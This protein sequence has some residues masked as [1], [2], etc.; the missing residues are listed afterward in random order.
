LGLCFGG[1]SGI[2]MALSGFGVWSLVVQQL[3]YEC[4]S[5]LVLWIASTWRPRLQFS[6]RHFLH[7]FHFGISLLAFNIVNFFKEEAN[8]FLVGY[9]MGPI[10]LGF[11]TIAEQV[12]A[13]VM[14]LVVTTSSPVA[15]PMFS[16]LQADLEQFRRVF[17]QA[18]QYTSVIALPT[19]LGMFLL[20][21]ELVLLVFGEQW[22]V[23]IPVLQLLALAGIVDAMSFFRGHI[24]VAMGKPSW[25]LWQSLLSLV[26]HAIGFAIAVRLGIVAVAIAYL[27][28]RCLVFPIGQWSIHILIRFSWQRYGHQFIAPMVSSLLMVVVTLATKHL[29]YNWISSPLVVV[30][31]C[32]AAGIVV[33]GLGIRILAPH[34]YHELQ[35]LTMT[36]TKSSAST[37]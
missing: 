16:R 24:L 6:L 4:G 36:A 34:I 26:L 8:D 21:P 25:R 7:M 20:A 32:T 29:L 9:F 18:T 10:T 27:V 19:F 12:V 2:I 28:R 23:A 5:A 17:Y 30:T 33:Y 15:L 13:G 11:Y 14:Q 31:V 37:L 22:T 1:V 3:G 35:A